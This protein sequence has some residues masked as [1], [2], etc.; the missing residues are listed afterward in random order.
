MDQSTYPKRLDIANGGLQTIPEVVLQTPNN[1]EEL[2]AGQNKL[3]EIAL[4]ALSTFSN[5]RILRLPGNDFRVFPEPLLHITAP[6]AVLDLADNLIQ[7]IPD[8]IGNL[9]K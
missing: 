1:V 8:E 3:Q 4:T 5:L 7:T 2:L 9:D 6:L